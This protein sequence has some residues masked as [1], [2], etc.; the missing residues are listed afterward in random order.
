MVMY[1]L[2]Y[3]CRYV[4]YV[5]LNVCMYNKYVRMLRVYVRYDVR[6]RNGC[7]TF[8]RVCLQICV[9]NVGMYVMCVYVSIVRS[10][11]ML[12]YVPVL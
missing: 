7:M 4:C 1:L 9:F 8:M 2:C 5:R 6:S 10:V 12:R 3:V 11:F